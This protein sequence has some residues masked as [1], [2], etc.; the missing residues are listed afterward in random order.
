MS[1]D[2][3]IAVAVH[4]PTS[5]VFGVYSVCCDG[6]GIGVVVVERQ[7]VIERF[8]T[9]LAARCETGKILLLTVPSMPER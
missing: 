6:E 5:A 8:V 9:L 7:L 1:T 4:I 2:Y 3:D